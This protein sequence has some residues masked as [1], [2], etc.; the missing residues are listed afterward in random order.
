VHLSL[1]PTSHVIGQL[2]P[3]RRVSNE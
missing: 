2:T 3:N 1:L